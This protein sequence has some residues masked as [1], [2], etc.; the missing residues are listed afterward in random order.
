M[1]KVGWFLTLALALT[2]ALLPGVPALAQGPDSIVAE[3]LN[4]PQGIVVAPDGSV[5]VTDSG[6]GG[7]QE[8]PALDLSSGEAITAMLGNSAHIVQI[9]ADGAQTV[10]AS[11]PSIVMGTETT[12]AGR[13]ALLGGVLYATSSL[14]EETFGPDPVLPLMGAVVEVAGGAATETANLWAF[15][16][17]QNPGGFVL[18]SHPYGITAG[19]DG[20]LWVAD[21]GGNDLLKVDPASGKVQLVAVFDGIPGPMPNPGRGGASESDPVPTAVAFDAAGN[22]Y[23]SLLP[24]FPFLPGSAK[25]VRVAPDGQVSDYATGLTMLTDLRTGPDGEMY[26]VQFGQFTEQGPVPNSG[27]L[28]RIKAGTASEV[29]A[30]GLSF[31]TSIA[32]NAAG[33]A[34]VTLNGVGAPGSGQVGLFRGLTARAGTPAAAASAP[35]PLPTTGGSPLGAGW[36]ALVAGLILTVAGLG[37]RRAGRVRSDID[38]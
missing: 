33:D 2:L 31:P 18:D 1:R 7:D 34:Y 38:R 20:L 14:W 12:G 22:A 9:A 10:A 35:V 28:I 21:A 5:W 29:I 37:L 24:G 16:K 13:L 36:L 3:G 25:V 26:A 8:V 6:L 32:F 23:V 27:A 11:L 17:A 15:E 30:S 19:P 4:G